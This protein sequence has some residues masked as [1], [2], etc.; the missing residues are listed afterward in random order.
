MNLLTWKGVDLHDFGIATTAVSIR[1]PIAISSNFERF[2]R[3]FSKPSGPLAA[4]IE[5]L[6]LGVRWGLALPLYSLLFPSRGFF[7]AAGWPHALADT[8]VFGPTLGEHASGYNWVILD[9]EQQPG[10]PGDRT[11]STTY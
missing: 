6:S 1:K 7:R 10:K 5:V 4:Q 11:E 9:E 8:P 3:G 2:L